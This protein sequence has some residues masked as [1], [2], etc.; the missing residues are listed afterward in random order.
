M[1]RLRAH[2]RSNVIGYVALFFALSTGSAV[3]LTGSN[4]VQS[5]D[6][7]P[8]SQVTAPDVAANAVNGSD[9]VDNSI[10]GADVAEG[11]LALGVQLAGYFEAEGATGSCTDDQEAGST[12]ASTG[13]TLA[14]S[15]QLLLNGSGRWH[16][17]ALND[18]IGPGA[19]T[20]DTGRVEG[21]CVLRV[22][23]TPIGASTSMGERSEGGTVSNHPSNAPGTMAL[24]GVSSV[25]AAGAHTADVFCTE[26][27]GDLDWGAISL[28]AA[29]VDN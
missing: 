28:T 19:G 7:G 22:D 11:T 21:S 9:V 5:D 2:I 24:T 18:G 3:A 27:D 16:T 26:V 8:G 25:L 10:T 13:I 6:L 12:C 20:D 17:F 14:R 15:G 4:T 29:R 23:G 1:S